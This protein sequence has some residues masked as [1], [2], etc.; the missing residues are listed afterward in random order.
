MN[1]LASE[2]EC[3]SGTKT[4]H[5]FWSILNKYQA[6]ADSRMEFCMAMCLFI[7]LMQHQLKQVKDI[8]VKQ[9]KKS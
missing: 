1:E 4:R 7:F 2:R 8:I 3:F 9:K 5:Q 6:A